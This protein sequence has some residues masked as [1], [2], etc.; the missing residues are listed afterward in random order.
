MIRCLYK[1]QSHP[2]N[3]PG[4]LIAILVELSYWWIDY[5][6][7]FPTLP[8]WQ[9]I[10]PYNSSF[11]MCFQITSSFEY[12]LRSGCLWAHS[13]SLGWWLFLAVMLTYSTKKW[14]GGGSIISVSTLCEVTGLRQRDAWQQPRCVHWS[15]RGGS[16][17]QTWAP[18]CDAYT[19]AALSMNLNSHF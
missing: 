11:K 6:R 18:G 17:C 7:L 8:P 13:A 4:I 2:P 1:L 16:H 5:T 10:Q 12:H 15:Q 9:S 14:G 19:L 3:K